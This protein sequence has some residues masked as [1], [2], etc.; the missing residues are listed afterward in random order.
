M[1]PGINMQPLMRV[2]LIILMLIT[3]WLAP[4]QAYKTER[5]VIV[6]IDGLR[7]S[8]GL[9][10]ST[11]QYVPNMSE[12]AKQGALVA[13]FRN[14]GR[15]STS[16]AV[17]AI[18]CGAWTDRINFSDPDCG[19]ASNRHTELPTV[20]EYY[21]MQLNRP[22][23]D[24]IYTL[25]ELCPWK[26]SFHPYYGPEFWPLYHS[27]GHSDTE[28][29][30][31][32]EQMIAS[33]SPG[34]LMMYLADVDSEGHS[35]NWDDYLQAVA[36]A[37]DIVG[38]LWE[39][40]QADSTYAG[41]TTMLVTN[42]HGRHTNDF[43]GHGDSCDG[44]RHIQLLA[45]GPDTP[46][47]LMSNT[48]RTIPDIAPTVGALLGFQTELA[49]GSAMT[50]LITGPVSTADPK[51]VPQQLK[52]SSFPN[53]FNPSTMLHY[54]VKE[55]STLEI[56]VYNLAGERITVLENKHHEAGEYNILWGGLNDSGESVEAGMYIC[57]LRSVDHTQSIK[58]VL[59]K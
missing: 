25:K 31:E 13:D 2:S 19:G 38:R 47:G 54:A 41:H 4:A 6:I 44:C 55:A 15:T 48:P 5:V 33:H 58:M 29:W 14:D 3:F 46:A 7:Y 39:T 56:S 11:H 57:Q 35:G 27:E 23:T 10:D 52:L 37:D 26:A 59:L 22:E 36:T 1:I 24:C 16:S 20:F 42:D 40:L 51:Q 43:T 12:L 9:G 17:P 18:W 30:L 8:E 50:E 28:V 45:I 49:T 53:P 21:R 34:L 32:T